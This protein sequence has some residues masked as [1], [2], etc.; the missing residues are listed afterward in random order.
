MRTTALCIAGIALLIGVIADGA[1]IQVS[2]N[3]QSAIDAASPGD[4]LQV[5]PGV[6]DKITIQ[7]SINL[8][9]NGATIRAGNRD[10]CVSI[11]ADDVSS[12]ASWFGTAFMG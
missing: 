8:V 1:T 11:E 9:G 5:A 7:K 12:L 2:S 4:T 10:A 3:L 6:Y